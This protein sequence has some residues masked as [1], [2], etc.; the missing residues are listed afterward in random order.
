MATLITRTNTSQSLALSVHNGVRTT[1]WSVPS[2]KDESVEETQV[3][4]D[5]GRYKGVP[6]SENPLVPPYHWHWNQ[7]EYFH[8]KR[9]RFIFTLEGTDTTYSSTSPQPIFVPKKARHTFRVDPD[10]EEEC[11][12]V[13]TASPDDENSVSERFFRNLYSYLDDCEKQKVSPSL[14]QLLCFIHSAGASLALPGPALV[15]QWASWLLGLVVGRF[16]GWLLGYKSSYPEY[17]DVKMAKKA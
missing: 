14:V 17:Y 7:D 5:P 8:I 11:E 9:G 13:I 6:L 4:H 16:G 3:I 1:T 12:L 15:S 10:C 2:S